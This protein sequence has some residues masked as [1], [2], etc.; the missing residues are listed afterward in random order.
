MEFFACYLLSSCNPVYLDYAYIGF[1]VNPSRRIRQHNGELVNGAWFTKKRRPWQMVLCVYGFPSK[2]AALQFEWAWQHPEKSKLLAHRK[3]HFRGRIGRAFLLRAKFAILHEMLHCK[4]W[5][6]FAL[7]VHLFSRE[8]YEDLVKSFAFTRAGGSGYALMEIPPSMS[9]VFGGFEMLDALCGNGID[10]EDVL[11]FASYWGS[12][13]RPEG[14][15]GTATEEEPEEEE[16]DTVVDVD[17]LCYLCSK[18]I[19]P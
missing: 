7:T 14:A 9:R 19:E 4:P 11:N 1:T 5:C 6:H 15:P 8:R 16:E 18:P 17:L 3:E 13:Q 2:V 10:D 12:A